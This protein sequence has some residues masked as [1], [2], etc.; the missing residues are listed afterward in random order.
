M[1]NDSPLGAGEAAESPTPAAAPAPSVTLEQV[2]QL[3][4]ESQETLGRTLDTR[5]G[6]LAESLRPAPKAPEPTNDD[7]FLKEFAANPK[8]V[9]SKAI[10]EAVSPTI[11]QLTT[12]AG[13]AFVDLEAQTVDQKWG[14]GAWEKFIQPHW[15][16]LEGAYQKNNPAALSD[17]N[18]IARE[19]YSL[20][21]M[22]TDGLMK[23]KNEFDKSTSE[24]ETQDVDK[25]V[26]TV[27]KRVNLTGGLRPS[28]A[29]ESD[30]PSEATSSISSYI[31]RRTRAI[32][33][34]AED[35]KTWWKKVGSFDGENIDQWRAHKAKLK[36]KEAN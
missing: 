25:L 29:S 19:V 35:P 30:L 1:P 6:Q 17:R 34:D 23:H 9:L 2:S 4:R 27:S 8:E 3:I 24:R 36:S 5:I 12:S 32:G 18:L 28:G 16:K 14:T 26:E 7:D 31:E 15:A 10:S 22:Q 33:G 20:I 11:T 21:G 13:R